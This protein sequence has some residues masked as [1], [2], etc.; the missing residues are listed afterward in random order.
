[1]PTHLYCLLPE[2]SSVA[3]PAASPPVRALA[4]GGVIAWVSD[5]ATPRLSRDV[6]DAAKATVEHDRVIG[7]ALAQGVTPVPASLADPYESDA[8]ALADIAPHAASIATALEA[9]QGQVEMT[10]IVAI[11]DVVPARDAEGRGRAYLEQ[12]R[13]LPSRASDLADRLEGELSK[14]AGPARRRAH[15][16]RVALSHL[17][18]LGDVSR[19]REN[20]LRMTENGC[21]VVTDGPRAPYSFASFIPR[22]GFHSG[23]GVTQV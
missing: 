13:S 19:Y 9:I 8:E 10:I 14:T 2:G 22:R 18:A 17:V 23:S 21:R 6:R 16:G 3:V 4:A 1:M 12:L 5:A 7:T 20:V 15:G 11:Q